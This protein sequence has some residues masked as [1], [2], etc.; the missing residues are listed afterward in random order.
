[1]HRPVSAIVVVLMAL[2]IL[3]VNQNI[4]QDKVINLDT[5]LTSAQQHAMGLHKLTAAEKQALSQYLVLV[6]RA[7]MESCTTG[8]NRSLSSSPGNPGGS[9]L[10][11]PRSY[12]NGE[13]HWIRENVG[14]GDMLILEDGSVWKIN[15]VYRVNAMLW[16]PVSNI[17]VLDG[18]GRC[19]AGEY[20]LVNSDDGESACAAPLGS[21]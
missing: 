1:M 20:L 13:R 9:T 17:L 8:T 2:V 15:P 18:S 3:A 12:S 16:L 21:Q 5:I 6:Y 7:G 14:S 4:A 11:A 10:H 19:Q